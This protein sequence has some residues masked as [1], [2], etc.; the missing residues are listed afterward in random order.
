M[1]LDDGYLCRMPR[2]YRAIE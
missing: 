2:T 1:Y